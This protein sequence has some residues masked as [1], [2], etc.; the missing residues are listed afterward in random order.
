MFDVQSH[1]DPPVETP[2]AND[3]PVSPATP[4]HNM[5]P[6]AGE[7]FVFVNGPLI[8]KHGRMLDNESRSRWLVELN[9]DTSGA[10][11]YVSPA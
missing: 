10:P 9:S 7:T 6:R 11:L 8:G 5:P 2:L 4:M 3:A 1:V